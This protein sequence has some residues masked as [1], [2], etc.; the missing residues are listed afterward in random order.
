MSTDHGL[1]PQEGAIIPCCVHLATKTQSF[2]HDEMRA[3]RGFIKVSST[4]TYWCRKTHH[5]FGPDNDAAQALAC[6][7]GRSCYEPKAP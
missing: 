4:A 2:M 6:Q 5:A 3:G 7:Q 1:L